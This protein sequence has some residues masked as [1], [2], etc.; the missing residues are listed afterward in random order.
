MEMGRR[1]A[2]TPKVVQYAYL[3]VEIYKDC[4]WDAHI[5]N[6]AGKG[7]SHVRIGKMDAMLSKS[8]L[9]TRIKR[10]MLLDVIVQA[11]V[12]RISMGR[13]GEGCKAAENSTDDSRLRYCQGVRVRQA[14]LLY[15]TVSDIHRPSSGKNY[16]DLM[17]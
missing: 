3:G 14:L 13:N 16:I 12:C 4:S 8:H 5:A 17:Y 10:C 1:A 11:R 6:V 7:K 9:D 2:C 15:L